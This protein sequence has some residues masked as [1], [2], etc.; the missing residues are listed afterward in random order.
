MTA[1][2]IPDGRDAGCRRSIQAALKRRGVLAG[3]LPQGHDWVHSRFQD[4]DGNHLQASLSGRG[5]TAPDLVDGTYWAGVAPP[6][7]P[8]LPPL[9]RCRR[10]RRRSRRSS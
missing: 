10:G 3:E 1:V 8:S 2:V 6:G 9:W 7:L 5:R 4:M